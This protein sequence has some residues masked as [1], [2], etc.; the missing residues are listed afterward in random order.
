MSNAPP[1]A[2][3]GL[4]SGSLHVYVAFDWGDEVNLD[5]ARRIA[6]ADLHAFPRKS[7]TPSS[8]G[9]QPPPLRF[10]LSALSLTLPELGHVT[11][12]IDATVFDFGAV[13]A[14]A[15]VPFR[16]SS[17]AL[18]NLT[19]SLAEPATLLQVVRQA[20]EPLFEK[21]KPA[22]QNPRWSELSEEYIVIQMVPSAV[23]SP[24]ELL[25]PE[26]CA[27]LAG[28]VRLEADPLSPSEVA[29]ALRMRL[30]YSPRDLFVPDWAAAVIVDDDCDEIL[31]AIA[32][33][34]LQLLEMRHI[35][36][37]LDDRMQDTYGLIRDLART[38]FPWWRTQ[39]RPIR[40]LGE[41][42]VEANVML[43]RSGDALKLVGDP[44][45][46]RVY[47]LLATRFHLDEWGQ[48]IRRSIA[49]LE[50][51]YQIVSD[52]AATYRTEILEVVIIVLILFE[53]VMALI[54]H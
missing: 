18:T 20:V 37:R 3:P 14:A 6:P 48:N 1:T 15:H 21:L 17:A 51:I 32:F 42:K 7:R 31:D 28:L 2:A 40:A 11:A 30:S 29:E 34:N 16:I 25:Q 46:A 5:A 44:Y 36:R 39:N 9:Y 13:S 26:Q 22:L 49:V 50:G 4:L 23:P 47:H 24:Q 54:R 33:A 12:E 27:W 41:L 52:Q 53:I 10:K 35:D 8:I 19:A 45:L 43:E 38:R